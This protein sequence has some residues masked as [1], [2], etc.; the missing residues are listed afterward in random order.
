MPGKRTEPR[1]TNLLFITMFFVSL[2]LHSILLVTSESKKVDDFQKT[3]G[4]RFQ[5]LVQTSTDLPA[6]TLPNQNVHPQNIEQPTPLKP[7][8]TSHAHPLP[9]LKKEHNYKKKVPVANDDTTP[10][11]VAL[12]P[13]LVKSESGK[14]TKQKKIEKRMD[15][16]AP[17]A[18]VQPANQSR[19]RNNKPPDDVSAIGGMDEYMQTVLRKIERK[20]HY[21]L[22]ARTRQLE[23]RTT[24]GFNLLANGYIEPPTVVDPSGYELL[25]QSA[26]QAVISAAPFGKPPAE[27][28]ERAI[29]L[30]VVLVFKL[31]QGFL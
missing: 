24:I 12:Q 10:P 27:F 5:L 20:K 26:L 4:V 3:K 23:G 2:A 11:I 31:Q 22:R 28:P 19:D 8:I 25:D 14:I 13:D 21:P 7:V 15:S 29:S 18:T 6:T 1:S 9:T 30:E 17:A 16:A